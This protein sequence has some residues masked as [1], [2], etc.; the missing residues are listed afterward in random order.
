[1]S[2]RSTATSV[3]WRAAGHVNFVSCFTYIQLDQFTASLLPCWSVG[4]Q[5]QTSISQACDMLKPR[6][7]MHIPNNCDSCR[8][9]V[10]VPFPIWPK[11]MQR[12]LHFIFM[13][14]FRMPENHSVDPS[15]DMVTQSRRN[16]QL[17]PPDNSLLSKKSW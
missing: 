9:N 3:T 7:A 1:V 11:P 6:L 8:E 16:E 12:D 17:V 15:H 5:S 2:R 4:C 14:C 10:Q 13:H